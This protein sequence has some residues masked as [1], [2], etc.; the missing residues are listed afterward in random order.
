MIL[1]YDYINTSTAH[2]LLKYYVSRYDMY[3]AGRDRVKNV[4]ART[5]SLYTYNIHLPPTVHVVNNTSLPDNCSAQ[6]IDRLDRPGA[7]RDIFASRRLG[8]GAVHG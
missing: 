1:I 6:T 7:T 2:L 3:V 5:C 4:R 8:R